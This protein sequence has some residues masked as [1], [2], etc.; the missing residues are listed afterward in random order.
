MSR[1]KRWCDLSKSEKLELLS[2]A[3]TPDERQAVMPRVE[4]FFRGR[5]IDDLL[6]A[7]NVVI[8]EAYR[9][10]HGDT[11]D[12]DRAAAAAGVVIR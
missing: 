6:H 1:E 4:R 2:Q 10:K 3:L 12:W 9:V 11:T 7:T 8:R 5:R